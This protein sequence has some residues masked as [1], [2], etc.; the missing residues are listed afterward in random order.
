[1]EKN[2]LDYDLEN[3]RNA[4]NILKLVTRPKQMWLSSS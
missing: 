2:V 4:R 1:M 3:L